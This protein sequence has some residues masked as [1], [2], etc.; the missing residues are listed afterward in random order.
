LHLTTL[1]L[2]YNVKLVVEEVWKFFEKGGRRITALKGISFQEDRGCLVVL[3]LNGAGKTTLF[4]SILGLY[5]PDKGKILVEETDPVKRPGVAAAP[6]LPYYDPRLTIQDVIDILEMFFDV[7]VP[8]KLL[9]LLE[10]E[11]QLNVEIQRLSSGF[12]KRVRLLSALVQPSDVILLDEITNG[13]DLSA[14]RVFERTINFLKKKKLI[15]FATHI[16]EHA[17]AVGDRLLVL[18]EGELKYYGNM[19]E[20]MGGERLSSAF[21]RVIN[22]AAPTG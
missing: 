2:K 7:R 14:I 21:W 18:H 19:K 9:K 15:L 6:L 16:F 12:N 20:F 17:E 4:R 1:E 11:D 3:G 10:L 5:I 8:D 22:E 13:L